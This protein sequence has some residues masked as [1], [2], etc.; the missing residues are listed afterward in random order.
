MAK[1][2]MGVALVGMAYGSYLL[3]TRQLTLAA[4]LRGT[5][6]LALAAAIA[7]IWYLAVEL[8]EPGFLYYYFIERHVLGFAT[9]TQ[10]HGDA[11]WWLYLPALLGG[12][13]PWIGY[14]PATMRERVKTTGRPE[15]LLWCWLLGCTL[16]L[17]LAQ[18][19]LVTYI[20][21]V[22][23]AV[24]ILAA[25]GWS[26]LLE[27]TLGAPAAQSLRKNFLLATCL[28]PLVLPIAVLV[29][30]IR[31]GVPY[32]PSTWAAAIIAALATL[33]PLWFFH[34]GRWQAT[35]AAATL[36]A[37]VQFLVIIGLIVP[38]VAELRSARELA[39]YFNAAPSGVPMLPAKM[40]F[41]EERIGS[42]V[43]YLDPAL[44]ASIA[45]D[46]LQGVVRPKDP[47]PKIKQP[48]P[49][50]SVLVVPQRRREKASGYLDFEGTSA[51]KVGH[52]W[53]MQKPGN[54]A[55]GPKN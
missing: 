36:T 25:I 33:A 35:L 54:A 22:F 1:G 41:A 38:P 50:D 13:L 46:Q 21:P 40:R 52:Y 47:R 15:V 14:L 43:F 7:S 31:V 37:A 30:Q 3:I 34:R 39:A 53:L 5:A 16:L 24:A 28:G 45:E 49:A 12:G 9:S 42:F 29:L 55:D 10:K 8:R 20:W 19:K 4:C 26:R 18:S 11:P 27:G 44:R 32:G 6:A 51:V 48:F 2:L 23:P 17:S